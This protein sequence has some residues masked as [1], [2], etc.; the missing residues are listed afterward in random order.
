MGKVLDTDGIERLVGTKP[1]VVK[2]T[3]DGVH[4]IFGAGVAMADRAVF[5]EI[6]TC[7][8][9]STIPLN[10]MM[11]GII[12]MTIKIADEASKDGLGAGTGVLSFFMLFVEKISE[13]IRGNQP[14]V[15]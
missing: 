11:M 2:E 3:A 14:E 7:C 5:V 15:N 12:D 6:V 1:S 4:V 9:S 8:P 13:K 10:N